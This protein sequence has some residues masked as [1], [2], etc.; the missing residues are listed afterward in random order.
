MIPIC[1]EQLFGVQNIDTYRD[2]HDGQKR[3]INKI[4]IFMSGF[5]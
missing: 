5:F 1:R 4:E 3:K 2:M